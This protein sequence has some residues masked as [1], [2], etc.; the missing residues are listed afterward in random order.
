VENANTIASGSEARIELK[1]VLAVQKLIAGTVDSRERML[2]QYARRFKELALSQARREAEYH[3][4]LSAW[5]H[6]IG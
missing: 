3:L 1:R 2:P 6:S 5:Q 4:S